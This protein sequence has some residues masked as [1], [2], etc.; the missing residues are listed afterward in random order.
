MGVGVSQRDANDHFT[1]FFQTERNAKR[2]HNERSGSPAPHMEFRKDAESSVQS[3]LEGKSRVR[4]RVQAP[5]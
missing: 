2:K 4:G 5:R 1:C 3:L